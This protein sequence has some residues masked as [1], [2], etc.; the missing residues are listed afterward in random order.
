MIKKLK[1][2]AFS[3]VESLIR[4][5][6]GGL[7]QRLRYFYYSKRLKSCGKNVRI[8]EGV[9]IHNPQNI[10][11]G[12]DIWIL[13]YTT[14]TARNLE[15]RIGDRILIVKS[16]DQF[17]DD[18]GEIIIEDQVSIGSYNIIQGFGGLRIKSR[19]TTSARVSIY[20]YSHYPFDRS[21]PSKITYANSMVKSS[22]ISCI[23][24]PVVI[25]EGAWLGLNV[26]VMGGTI[27]KYSFVSSNSVVINGLPENSYASGYPAKKQK[28]RFKL[29]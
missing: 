6:S 28:N 1:I 25:E 18:E 9:I 11:M 21:N 14:I 8:D 4:N 13:P 20:S 7:G 29:E 22:D 10:R 17:K 23:S 26:I 24:S 27:G 2:I 19:V 5:I 16:N 15:Y 3:L 12:N